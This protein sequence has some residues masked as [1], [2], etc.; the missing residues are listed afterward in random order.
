MNPADRKC[1]L[2]DMMVLTA[3]SAIGLSGAMLLW[4][5]NCL[6]NFTNNRTVPRGLRDIP[7]TLYYL[8][9]WLFIFSPLGAAWTVAVSLLA[10]RRPRPIISELANQPG[11]AA[12]WTATMAMAIACG[13]SIWTDYRG[14]NYGWEI[15]QK[16]RPDETDTILSD[17]IYWVIDDAFRPI[18]CSV[19]C[20]WAIAVLGKRWTPA[21]NWIDRTGICLGFLWI[22]FMVLLVVEEPL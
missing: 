13:L 21:A 12:C 22:F 2:L 19:F 20:V 8:Y 11:I 14:G 4:Q 3:A 1:N 9:N 6:F 5:S 17:V 10:L 15:F 7:W 16:I 18:G